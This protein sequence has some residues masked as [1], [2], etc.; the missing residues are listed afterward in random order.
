[1]SNDKSLGSIIDIANK[2]KSVRSK[3]YIMAPKNYNL[4]NIADHLFLLNREV[5]P[6]LDPVLLIQYFYLLSSELQRRRV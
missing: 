2:I 4:T 1:V 5:H 3:C 6:I